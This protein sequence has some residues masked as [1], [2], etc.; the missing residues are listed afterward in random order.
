MD[1]ARI[2]SVSVMSMSCFA[3]KENRWKWLAVLEF[4][5]DF[6]GFEK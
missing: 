2:V 4:S 6:V 5:Y 3:A 1:E